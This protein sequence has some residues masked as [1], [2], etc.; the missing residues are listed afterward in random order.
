[1]KKL[2]L[3]QLLKDNDV[4]STNLRSFMNKNKANKELIKN[5]KLTKKW[6]VEAEKI[7]A[8]KERQLKIKRMADK[9]NLSVKRYNELQELCNT[10][11]GSI[12]SGYSMGDIKKV[13]V[14]NEFFFRRDDTRRYANSCSYSPIYG[15]IRLDINKKQLLS[16]EKKGYNG[17][18][19]EGKDI[20]TTGYKGSFQVKF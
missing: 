8:E 6:L 20:K 17:V 11:M 16:L 1:M 12:N 4:R 14:N 9:F 15:L 13:Y 3:L 5:T 18:T 10:L 7:E 2:E 19:C